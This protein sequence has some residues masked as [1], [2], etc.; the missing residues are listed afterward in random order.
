MALTCGARLGPYEVMEPL[1]SGG[2]GEVYRARDPR[3]GR[4]V[5][6]KL[7]TTDGTTS[8]DRLRRFETEARAVARLSHP[9]VVTVFDVG[10]HGGQPY[11]VLELLEGETLRG[12]LRGGGLSVREAVER[13]LGVARGLG[14][15]HER[16]IVHRDLKPENVFVTVDGRVKVLDFGLAKLREP[17]DESG[18]ESPTESAQTRPG[19]LVGTVGYMSPEQVRGQSPDARSDVFALG[20]VLYEML[21]GRRA[22]EGETPVDTLS[23]ILHRDPP[24]IASSGGP[25]PPGLERV[26]RRCLEKDPEE[27]FQSA[28]DVAFALEALSGSREPTERAALARPR[29]RW[30][31]AGAALVAL[32]A[33]ALVVA[34]AVGLRPT[35]KVRQVR[36]ITAGIGASLAGGGGNWATIV[37]DGV[38]AYYIAAKGGEQGL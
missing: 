16:G 11:L 9:N 13:G 3:L 33:A 28:R 6:V 10:T 15:A 7:V 8:P 23:A 32:T 19:T 20:A 18:R 17:V 30:L 25:P 34:A 27:R 36:R 31:P 5:A 37:S 4:D 35:P 1:G 21:S 14:A 12:A 38:R 2:M 29:R 26:V 22:F 24:E